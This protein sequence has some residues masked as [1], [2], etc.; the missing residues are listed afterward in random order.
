MTE[1]TPEI[2][3]R[4]RGADPSEVARRR[5]AN[6]ELQATREKLTSTSGLER[7]FDYELL[8]QFAET[9]RNAATV[10]YLLAAI[11]AAASSVW[12]STPLMVLWLAVVTSVMSVG[13]VV[14]GR[15]LRA[16]ADEVVTTTWRM[17][18]MATELAQ[19]VAWA[20]LLVQLYQSGSVS[21]QTFLLFLS[22]L[23]TAVTAML[24]ANVPVAVYGGIAPLTASIIASTSAVSSIEWLTMAAA[25]M[26]GQLYFA[27]LSN[28]L[29]SST[30]ATL[31]FRAE[32]D[33]LIAEL[34]QAKANSDQA[35]RRAEE[36]NIAK[37]HFLATMSHELRTPLNAIM[38]F[39]EVMKG[40]L[41]GQH[42]VPAYREYSNDIYSSGKLLLDI[43]NE[44]LD[45]S[46]IEAGRYELKEEAVSLA[47][48][49][50]DCRH[51]LQMRAKNR[52]IVIK[53]M[54]EPQLPKIWADERAIRQVALN[55]LSNAIKFTPSGGEVTIKVGWTS[56]GGQYL[57]IRDTGPGI[58]ED[59]IPIVLQSFGRGSLAIKTAEQG[60]GL[61]LPI[62]KG[63][64]D[65][66]GGQLILNSK[67]REGTEVVITF[68][69]SRVMDTL[70]PI[71]EPRTETP[72]VH[73][74]G[75]R[76]A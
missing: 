25:A 19:G 7:A 18:F 35:R 50:E 49:V 70:A 44:I 61:G 1:L 62:V 40:E 60:T 43:I 47:H 33:A 67:L 74:T 5:R 4:G 48:V 72:A 29:Y 41:F 17:R 68:P 52:S 36:A 32:K 64:M 38:G 26:G 65:M 39:S 15:F 56:S 14:A 31:E 66:H 23:I 6:R 59:E 73:T 45:L 27:I 12:L 53:E 2:I 11:V 3:Q 21:A 69:P 20:A 76:A 10:M 28:R 75:R 55:L 51:M 42:Q 8:R 13:F 16:P 58:P 71:A 54:I 63:L 30:I 46:R 9:R 34:E 24:S 37:S 22:L 57:S